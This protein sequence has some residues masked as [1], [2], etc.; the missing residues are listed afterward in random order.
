MTQIETFTNSHSTGTHKIHAP[1][2]TFTHTLENISPAENVL[3]SL[4]TRDGE[5][6]SH[7]VQTK[8]RALFALFSCRT[9][10]GVGMNACRCLA[11]CE[12]VSK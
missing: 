5:S 3:F 9:C 6:V 7:S 8:L 4:V 12:G 11:G 1:F 2:L 10:M